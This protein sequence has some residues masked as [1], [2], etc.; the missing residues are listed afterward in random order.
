M[1]VLRLCAAGSADGDAFIAPKDQYILI[2]REH[3]D[4]LSFDCIRIEV[5]VCDG[6]KQAREHLAV[7]RIQLFH[8]ELIAH[9]NVRNSLAD[10]QQQ[11]HPL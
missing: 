6:H 3:L 5:C 10:I 7:E 9:H 2:G 1:S 8:V 11:I 4:D